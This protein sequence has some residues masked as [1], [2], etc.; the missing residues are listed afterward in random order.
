MFRP[1][2]R[3]SSDRVNRC[4]VHVVIPICLHRQNSCADV[5]IN[6]LA[7]IILARFVEIVDSFR[8]T[9]LEVGCPPLSRVYLDSNLEVG[10]VTF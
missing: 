7:H 8:S 3:P 1:F 10:F 4:C 9:A 6:V 2:K 5:L